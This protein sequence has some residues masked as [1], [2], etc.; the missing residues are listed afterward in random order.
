MTAHVDEADRGRV[1]AGSAVR[2]RVDAVPDHELIGT[3]SDERTSKLHELHDAYVGVVEVLSQYLQSAHPKLKARS[4][5]VAE[6]SQQVASRLKLSARDIDDIRVGALLYDVGNIEI[7]TRVIRRAMDTLDADTSKLE[8]QTIQ[9]E[10]LMLSLGSVLNGAVPLLLNQQEGRPQENDPGKVPMG[11][12]IISTV[13]AYDALTEG[14]AKG[15]R[16]TQAAA[17][18]ELRSN[19]AGGYD[20]NVL[21]ALEWCLGQGS[22]GAPIVTGKSGGLELAQGAVV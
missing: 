21:T 2:I 8:P 10:D 20:A 11:A 3:L 14:A 5:R 9:G 13:R 18:A 15:Q 7:T 1:Q 19:K 12:R 16:L 17:F 4:T 22:T 6:L